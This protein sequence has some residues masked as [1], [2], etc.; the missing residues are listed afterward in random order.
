MSSV[1]CA[2]LPQDD[3]QAVHVRPLAAAL[4]QEQLWGLHSEFDVPL[5]KVIDAIWAMHLLHCCML[6]WQGAV[7]NL[8][9]QLGARSIARLAKCSLKAAIPGGFS[10]WGCSPPRRG[11]Q[12]LLWRSGS[13]GA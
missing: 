11:C 4:P 1:T 9:L 13:P 3:A 8:Q 6:H 7:P 12:R 5:N 10:Q 2:E